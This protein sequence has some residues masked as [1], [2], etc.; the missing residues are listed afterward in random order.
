GPTNGTVTIATDGTFSYVHDG[1]DTTSDSF[2]YTVKDA[3]GEVSNEATVAVTITAVNDAPVAYAVSVSGPED[4]NISMTL[5]GS[6]VDGIVESF[7]VKTLPANGILRLNT[8]PV[9]AGQVIQLADADKL[10][11]SPTL[12]YY[13]VTNFDYTAVDN[14]GLESEIAVVGITVTA[15]NDAPVADDVNVSGP[16]DTDLEITLSGIDVDGTIEI[17]TVKSLPIKGVLYL[18]SNPVVLDQQI[19]FADADKLIFSPNL[20]YYGNTSFIYTATDNHGLEGETAVVSIEIT[21]VNDVPVAVSDNYVIKEEGTVTLTPL[22]LDT[23]SDV[24]DVLSIVSIN[25]VQLTGGLQE[26]ITPNG[27][28]Y[29]DASDIITFTPDVDYNGTERFAYVITDGTATDTANQNIE[30]TPV[31]DAAVIAGDDNGAVEEDSSDP[32]LTDNGTL[33]ISDADSGEASF[34]TTGIVA[35]ADAL[36]S[37]TIDAAGEWTY[38]VPNGDVQYLSEGETKV[39][40]FKVFSLDGTEH[41]ITITITGV[42]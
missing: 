6:D 20:N 36:G 33:T 19:D 16:E 22:D 10:I 23:D 21:S 14:E 30:V 15:L 27:K 11:F 1:T 18:N 31:N 12:N 28:V 40:T 9:I 42:N 13:G 34:Q 7:I 5:S 35:S 39:E 29:I 37:L 4:T 25:G 3:D 41:T 26:I 2:T 24:D 8:V 32:I 38:T 17:F